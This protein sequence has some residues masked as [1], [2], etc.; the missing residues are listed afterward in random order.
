MNGRTAYK[1]ARKSIKGSFWGKRSMV[2]VRLPLSLADEP[3]PESLF[4]ENHLE[5][6]LPNGNY[7]TV[8]F[9]HVNG[10]KDSCKNS[11]NFT[12][13]LEEPDKYYADR[14]NW[15]EGDY[16]ITTKSP[17]DDTFNRETDLVEEGEMDEKS[18]TDYVNYKKWED[19]YVHGINSWGYDQPPPSN[20]VLNA[21]H[22]A[23]NW[24]KT[25]YGG[26]EGDNIY[27]VYS[28]KDKRI[29]KFAPHLS[30]AMKFA[31]KHN[32]RVRAFPAYL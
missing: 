17:Y 30:K 22:Q 9:H 16:I 1:L 23:A 25:T 28:I 5:I 13:Y 27:L 32:V 11:R 19:R 4:K 20:P 24:S 3:P 14:S 2:A 31:K 6:K 8:A 10:P 7:K 12:K 26:V 15:W 21:F 18:V 29:K